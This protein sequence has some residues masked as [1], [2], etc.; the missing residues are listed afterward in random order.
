MV[1]EPVSILTIVGITIILGYISS[2]IF[3]KTRIPDVIFLLMFGVIVGPQILN[4]VDTS[5]YIAVS[6]LLSVITLILLLFDSGLEMDIL[7]MLKDISR[8]AIL[9][10]LTVSLSTIG[11]MLLF[12]VLFPQLNVL[13]ALLFGIILSGTATEIVLPLLQKMKI[14][15][16][17]RTVLE[18]ET[19][20]LD[21][22]TIVT[23]LTLIQILQA[24]TIPESIQSI[25]FNTYSG[26][27]LIGVVVGLIW[28]V[29]LD[30]MKSEELDYILTLGVLFLGYVAAEYLRGSG[31]MFALVFGLVLGNSKYFSRFLK[32]TKVIEADELIKKFQKEITFFITSFFFVYTG[33]I[34][35][36]NLSYIFYGII[37]SIA[38]IVL[39]MAAIKIGTIGMNLSET[40]NRIARTLACRG[41]ATALLAQLPLAFGLPYAD[42]ILNITFVVILST[43]IYTTI[44]TTIYYK[45]DK[46]QNPAQQVYRK[47]P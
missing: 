18:L 47:Y 22:I 33:L 12:L 26:P 15:E 21:P 17:F 2:F 16:K 10:I 13:T 3:N 46:L 28:L 44:F 4:L 45:P 5:I 43:V 41:L 8:G 40:E 34:I 36:I 29:I 14:R 35:Q 37:F 27:I 1:I 39:R 24:T 38:L 20:V 11:S 42:L 25:L 31:V 6:L 7:E 23:V 30:R 9:A 19:I 32:L